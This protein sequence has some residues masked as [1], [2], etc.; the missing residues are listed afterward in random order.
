M[1][2]MFSSA[3]GTPCDISE[4]ELRKA[5]EYLGAPAAAPA[6]A[7]AFQGFRT[8]AGQACASDAAAMARAREWL[9][10]D[11]KE[12]KG[13]KVG[14]E[15]A[16]AAMGAAAGP[17]PPRQRQPLHRRPAAGGP[18]HPSAAAPGR[19][20]ISAP[21]PG[22]FKRPRPADADAGAPAGA[23]PPVRPQPAVAEPPP[24]AAPP[25]PKASLHQKPSAGAATG[26]SPAVPA[27]CTCAPDAP[28]TPLHKRRCPS[29]CCRC[30]G[31]L[32]PAGLQAL[33]AQGCPNTGKG[34]LW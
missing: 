1:S 24:A 10:A 19:A 27:H 7:P 23:Q 5:Q 25:R 30:G 13:A 29:C 9:F 20:N 4:E 32:E 16:D 34:P 12:D 14:F 18:L 33:H 3:A 8:G 17:Q 26:S 15:S 21:R 22:G 2:S 31:R 28:G 6:A 11:E